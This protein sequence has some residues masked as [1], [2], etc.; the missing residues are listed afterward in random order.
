[1]RTTYAV[2]V[3]GFSPSLSRFKVRDK[4]LYLTENCGG[5][6]NDVCD[7]KSGTARIRFRTLDAAVR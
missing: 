1:M 7:I 2:I 3:R 5:S 6:V 4:L